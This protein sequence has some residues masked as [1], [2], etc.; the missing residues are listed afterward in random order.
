MSISNHERVG[1]ALNLLKEGLYPYIEREMRSVYRDKW[2]LAAIPLIDPDNTLRRKPEDILKEDVSAQLKLMWGKWDDVFKQTLGQTERT[3]ISELRNTRNAWAHGS[4]S[5]PTEDAYRALDSIVRLLNAIGAAEQSDIVEKQRSELM[6]QRYEDQAR[7]EAR[8]AAVAPMEGTPTGGLKPWRE[9]VMPHQDVASGRYQQAEFAA[10]LWQVFLDEGSDEYR[11]PTEFFRRTYLTE[12]LKQLLSGALLRLSGNKSDPVIE[13][14]TNFGGGKTHAML[15]LFHLFSGVSAKQLPGL[16]SVFESAKV[17][18]PPQNVNMVVLVG[19]KISPG[20]THIKKDGTTVRTLWG[21][22]AWQ[23]GGKEGYEMMRQAD[24]TSTNPGDTLKLLFNKY[25]PCLILI[26]EWVSYARQL[27]TEN[28]LPAGTFDTHFTFAQ[29]LSESAKNADRTLLVVSIPSSDIEIGGNR[30]QEALHRLKNAIGRVESPWRPASA[31]ESFEIVRRRLFQP[32]DSNSY[33][34]RDAVIRAF[35]EMYQSQAAEFPSECREANYKRRLEEAY[36]IHPE[37]FDRLYSDWS[38]L[39]KFQRTRGVLRLMAKVIHSLWDRGDKNLLIMP[40]SVAMD[41]AQVQSELTRYLDDN[42]VPVIEKDVDGSN[43]LPVSLDS[44]NPNLGRYSACRRVT[45]T[46]YL[47]SAPTLRAANRGLPDRRIRLGCVQPGESVATFGDALR[48]LTDQA[49]YIYIDGDR[50][51]ISTQPNVTRMAQDRATQIQEDPEKIWEEIVR[52]LKLDKQRGEFAGVHIASESTADIP[53]D[54]SMGVRLVVLGPQHPHISRSIDS[55]ARQQSEHTLMTRGASPRYCKNLLLFLAPDKSKLT[56]LEQNVCQ[57][58]AWNSIVRDKE[59]LNL[60]P[61]Q[62]KQA[63]TKQEQ[64]DDLVDNLLKEAYSWLLVPTHRSNASDPKQQIDWTEVR[65]QGQDSPVL[66]ASRKA[67]HEEYLIVTYAANRIRMEALDSY[68]W[69]DS[70]HIDTKRLWTY[71]SNYLYFPRLSNEQ[72]LLQAIQQGV[73]A[74]LW[75]EHFAYATGWDEAK[76]RYLGL[77]AGPNDPFTATLSSQNLLVKPEVAQRQL[78][79]DEAAR[80][81]A[82]NEK[83]QPGSDPGVE[84]T[85]N[86]IDPPDGGTKPVPPP[87]TKQVNRFYAS[88]KVNPTRLIKDV[89]QIADEVLQHLSSL[90]ADIEVTVEIQVKTPDGVPDAIVRTVTE[91]CRTLK[92]TNYDFEEE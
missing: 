44:Q 24:E 43:S 34:A 9:I 41:D 11:D 35:Y 27:H 6:R 7:R 72:V 62:S 40:A 30:G 45:R 39:D 63:T 31:E 59:V 85:D 29:T 22:I 57:F 73:T 67:V 81:Q 65:L 16:E 58:L 21:E 60:D 48:R 87:P 37:L 61:F 10:D 26:D 68:L 4:T 36:P 20:Q 79:A 55:P 15:G 54:E 89:G 3:L 52:R 42:W 70:D 74:L 38:T 69:R 90:N 28:D 53:D 86:P 8:R 46:I 66:R 84:E 50:Y 13:L 75:S 88:V 2:L 17:P 76:G 18:E 71:L 5:V 80:K 12:G 23:L 19:N 32:I 14:Q 78:D 91:N 64:T 83:N 25:S 92:F 47:G 77:K 1:R 33:V 56:V 82:E 49:S 51:W